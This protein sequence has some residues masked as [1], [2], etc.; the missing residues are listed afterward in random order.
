MFVLQALLNCFVMFA[1]VYLGI[2]VYFFDTYLFIINWARKIN[3]VG[4]D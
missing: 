1:G 2:Y 4:A 3:N